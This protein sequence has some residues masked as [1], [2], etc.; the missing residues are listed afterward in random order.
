MQRALLIAEKKTMAD[1]IEKAYRFYKHK[2][3][4]ITFASAEGHLFT[5]YEPGDYKGEE[6]K[7]WDIKALPIIPRE[8][9]IKP[10][11]AGYEKYSSIKKLINSG[12]FDVVIHAGDSA[13]EGELII[14]EILSA[15]GNKLPELRLWC[16]DLSEEGIW[17][18]FDNL[19]MPQYNLKAAARLRA[20]EDWLIGINA[21]R[22]VS[23]SVNETVNVGRVMTALLSLIVKRDYEKETFEPR[24]Y[25]E[26]SFTINSAKGSMPG[27]LLREKNKMSF[28]DP[29]DIK[30]LMLSAELEGFV[31]KVIKTQKRKQVP[32]LHDLAELQKEAYSEFGFSPQETLDIAQSLYMKQLISYPRTD[33][34]YISRNIAME[35]TENLMALHSIPSF[36]KYITDIMED[37]NKTEKICVKN[38][39]WVDDEKLTDHHAIIPTK[40]TPRFESMTDDELKIYLLVARRLLAIFMQDRITERTVINCTFGGINTTSKGM[41][42]IQKGFSEIMPS[43]ISE[44][45]LPDLAEN[46]IVELDNA[47]LLEKESASPSYFNYKTIIEAMQT[48]GGSSEDKDLSQTL[49]KTKG[50]GTASTR[51]ATIEK[52]L[53]LGYIEI[54]TEH[55][56]RHIESTVIGRNVYELLK[57]TD[58]ASVILTAKM[59]QDLAD[60]EAGE[61]SY[62]DY[63]KDLNEQIFKMTRQLKELSPEDGAVYAVPAN[64]KRNE[65]VLTCPVCKREILQSARYYY[66]SGKR[67]GSCKFVRPTIF[68]GARITDEDMKKLLSGNSITKKCIWKNNS[69]SKAAI[70]LGEDLFEFKKK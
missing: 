48:A 25:Y 23:L 6:W 59:E 26:F 70:L 2:K 20:M 33:C 37:K 19:K 7:K 29:E 28:D 40:V 52:L 67:N 38:N 58:L 53:N 31:S 65:D 54:V 56:H 39:K 47:E 12:D 5:L 32:L 69:S 62:Q 68:F 66:C 11:K 41:V 17:K 64:E 21:S 8:F 15:S 45:I 43:N 63:Y 9:M 1:M 14:D 4:E 61:L 42:I 30:E 44:T 13:R 49:E 51:A 35:L 55:G 3:Y 34:R 60:V 24:K 27:M 18:A 57:D 16:N 36:Y 50:I 46:D 22:A 10:T